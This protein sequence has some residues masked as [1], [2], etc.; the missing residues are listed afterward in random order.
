MRKWRQRLASRGVMCAL[1][2]ALCF[3]VTSAVYLSWLDRLVALT[4]D[5]ATNWLSMGAGYLLQAAGMAAAVGF[6]RRRG[7]GDF[8]TA[9]TGAALLFAAVSVPALLTD[10]TVSVVCFGMLMNLLCG[11]IS[12][13]YLYAVGINVPAERRGLAFGG[14]YAAATIAVGLLALIDGGRL[15]HGAWALLIYLPLSVAMGPMAARGRLLCSPGDAPRQSD[16]AEK[17]LPLACAVIVLLSAVKNMG[18]SFPSADIEAG[19]IPELS[20]LPY[21]LGLAAA[22]FINDKNR[23][24]GMACT[25]A[26]LI[27]PFIMLGLT[28]ESVPSAIC[29]G[30]DYLFFG[31]FSVFRATL[32]MDIADRAGRWYLAPLGLLMGRLGDVAGTVVSLLLLEHRVAL[33]AV[34]TL[35]F[36]PTALLF[37]L[38]YRRLYEPE[39]AQERSA[40][41][42]FDTF[43]LHNDL[44]AREREVLRMILDNRTNGEIAEALFITESTVKYHVRNVLQKAG[45]KNRGELQRKYTLALYP[46][47]DGAAQT[48]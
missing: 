25:L 38:L 7:G 4:G 36:F 39:V 14:S 34:T 29:W 26:A 30:L 40:Q 12:G 3:G 1:W 41:E 6:I 28:R 17:L 10:S 43:C 23:R 5:R 16:T 15:L 42:V 21:A 11:I 22:G 8:A 46:R 19:L 44:S 2:V 47:L 45:C 27:L 48:E 24:Y 32:F 18:F 20:R 33:I 35:A 31:F 37:Y 13:F 9:M